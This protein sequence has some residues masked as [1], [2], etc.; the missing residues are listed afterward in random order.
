[1][2]PRSRRTGRGA[3]P[4]P[5]ACGAAASPG[6]DRTVRPHR[7]RDGPPRRRP[8]RTRTPG[9]TA[10]KISPPTARMMPWACVRAS[11]TGPPRRTARPA[12]PPRRCG[13]L[14]ITTRST[15]TSPDPDHRDVEP[16]HPG[17]AG[18]SLYCRRCC[19]S[20]RGTGT[21]TTAT[22]RRTGPGS[23]GART[24]RGMMP[25]ATPS[26]RSRCRRPHAPYFARWARRPVPE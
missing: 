14:R 24:N 18:P 5:G 6:R 12:W 15:M 10:M 23:R 1:M 25:A 9:A 21:R 22:A 13:A 4:I 7:A 8:R 16:V 19:T 11:I 17:G 26:S 20:S 2:G 3:P